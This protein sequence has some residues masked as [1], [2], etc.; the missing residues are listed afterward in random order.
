[1]IRYIEVAIGRLER[2]FH[3]RIPSA[4]DTRS[5]QP[6]ARLVVPFGHRVAIAYFI[7]LIDQP[8]VTE[9]KE[10]QAILD[11]PLPLPLIKLLQ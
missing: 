10:V 7:R 11:N 9:T 6:G 2:L 8:E 1:M 4:L 5:L 3:Y